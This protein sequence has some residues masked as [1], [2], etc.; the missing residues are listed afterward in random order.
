MVLNPNPK[1]KKI[2]SV[3]FGREI[4]RKFEK[5]VFGGF[6]DTPT[7]HMGGIEFFGFRQNLPTYVFSNIGYREKTKKSFQGV[8][9]IFLIYGFFP[10]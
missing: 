10:L 1:S 9:R 3:A 6:Q 7:R 5:A 2:F 4:F 8:F